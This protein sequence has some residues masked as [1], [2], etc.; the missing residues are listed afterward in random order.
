[1]GA[2]LLRPSQGSAVSGRAAF[3]AFPGRARRARRGGRAGAGLF[4]RL[5][6]AMVEPLSEMSKSAAPQ[7]LRRKPKRSSPPRASS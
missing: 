7:G 2:P 6:R 3:K 5:E 1:M 4:P